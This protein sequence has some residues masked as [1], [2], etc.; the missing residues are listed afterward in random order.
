MIVLHINRYSATTA[1]G[2]QGSEMISHQRNPR[3]MQDSELERSYVSEG[4][5][6]G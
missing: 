2:E 1:L 3:D 4:G 6:R 5:G